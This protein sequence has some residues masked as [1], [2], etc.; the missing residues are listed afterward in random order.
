M[1][2]KFSWFGHIRRDG[3]REEVALI[4]MDATREEKKRKT[5]IDAGGWNL[6]GDGGSQTNT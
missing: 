5:S 4:W 1:K 6:K 3:T 2:Q